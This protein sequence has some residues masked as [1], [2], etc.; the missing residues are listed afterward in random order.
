MTS[1]F[2]LYSWL[3]SRINRGTRFIPITLAFSEPAPLQEQPDE[4]FYLEILV[5]LP[6]KPAPSLTHWCKQAKEAKQEQITGQT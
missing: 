4:S 1:T 2:P 3:S 6:L 5:K